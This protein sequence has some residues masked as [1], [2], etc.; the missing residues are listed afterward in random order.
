MATIWHDGAVFA[1]TADQ[2]S[3]EEAERIAQAL[4]HWSLDSRADATSDAAGN[5]L[6]RHLNIKDPR[7]LN[8]D[9]LY[10]ERRSRNDPKWMSFPVGLLRN[11]QVLNHVIRARDKKGYGFHGLMPGTSGSGKS[12]MCIVF[13]YSMA[14]THSATS[15]N[16]VYIDMKKDSAAQDLRGLPNVAAALSDLGEDKRHLAERMRRALLGEMARRYELCASVGA[17]DV[18][19]YEEFRAARVAAGT[20]DLPPIP[21]LFIIADEYLTLF[22]KNPKYEDLFMEL[23]EKGRGAEMYFLLAG[24]RLELS[25]LR[26]FEDNIAYRWVLRAESPGS[27][28]DWC[29]TDAAYRAIPAEEGGHGLLKVGE[30]DLVPYRCFFLSADFEVPPE[31]TEEQ[32]TV[33]VAFEKPRPLTATYQAMPGLDEM[34]AAA[35]P[36]EQPARYLDREDGATLL[37]EDDPR[38]KMRVLDV[39]RRSLIDSD[40]ERPPAIWL[41][42]LEEPEPVDELVAK[43]RGRPWYEDYGNNEGLFLLAGIEDISFRCTQKVHALDVGRDNVM[44]V[45]TKGMGKTTT[46]M[47]LVTSG[48][49]LYKP[50]R[51][52]FMCIGE[53]SMFSLE[54]WPHVAMVS[55]RDD[56]E[57]VKR[58]LASLEQIRRDRAEAF[59]RAKGMT[60]EELR[61][62]KFEGAEGWTDPNDRFGDVFLVIDDF[63]AFEQRYELSGLADRAVALADGGPTYGIHL[64]VSHSDWISGQREA[65][66]NVSN[67]RIELQ[68]SD[69][70]RT[71]TGDREM[72]KQ[73]G[74]MKQPGFAATR[75]GGDLGVSN[76]LLIGVPELVDPDTGQRLGAQAA[77][78]LVIKVAGDKHYTVDRLPAR[79][80][81]PQIMAAVP[82]AADRW[83]VPFALGENAMAPVCLDWR[84]T[85]NFLAVG[86]KGCG[87]DV[88]LTAVMDSV[89]SL[90]TPDQVQI[91]IFDRSRTLSAAAGALN[92]AYLRAYAYIDAEITKEMV[93]L[94][95]ELSGR[96]AP[97]GLDPRELGQW[98]WS[99]PRHL[100]II[101]DEHQIGQADPQVLQEVLG[102]GNAMMLY[103]FKQT[104]PLHSLLVR[105]GQIGLHVVASR[106]AGN[107]DGALLGGGFVTKMMD[108]RAPILFMD[109]D[110]D[111]VKLKERVRA[112]SQPP[113]RGYLVYEE[114]MEKVLV[115][116][117]SIGQG[118]S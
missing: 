7:H 78:G 35:E 97:A 23:G 33:E 63:K 48:C 38:P 109:N 36:K 112:E 85:A 40:Q 113:G 46:L 1:D 2:L 68:I 19:G 12:E 114:T 54:D 117:P 22:R 105:A 77:T 26:K 83:L 53:A 100:V 59:K 90:Y 72:A 9:E 93:K 45:G 25:S 98:R 47:T 82:G 74:E 110:G 3:C 5:G 84:Q 50:D 106:I 30:R 41:D 91:T 21:A 8:L 76:E 92:P 70:G 88:V 13:V 99:G 14:L 69:A 11:G 20:N 89:T 4:A 107:W 44:V 56:D 116:Y 34:L 86:K 28:R 102:E 118:N 101:N 96:L 57:G 24:Q 6:L 49:L 58:I 42:P 111:A 32:S 51:V 108:S 71:E 73:L 87:K 52:T 29:G 94:E 67:A 31:E 10:A 81:L 60:I 64:M 115:G 61:A 17:R 37:A 18:K 95:R 80:E 27:S 75:A 39:L 104:Q 65:L 79:V 55:S 62:R 66:K 103:D 43:W 15:A 16:V